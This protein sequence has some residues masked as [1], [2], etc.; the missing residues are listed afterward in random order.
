M[1]NKIKETLAKKWEAIASS[2]FMVVALQKSVRRLSRNFAF[3]KSEIFVQKIP[4]PYFPAIWF[5]PHMI[6]KRDS[7]IIFQY[8][9]SILYSLSCDRLSVEF[10]HLNFGPFL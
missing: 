4:Y 3:V 10:R 5:V 6:V 9:P 7:N 2:L 1:N 8:F